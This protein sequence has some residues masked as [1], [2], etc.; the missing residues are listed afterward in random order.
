MGKGIGFAIGL[1]VIGYMSLTYFTP[2]PLTERD[3]VASGLEQIK[4]STDL[5]PR[6]ESMMR[7]QL[8]IMDQIA[9]TGSPPGSLNELVPNYFDAVPVDPETKE[10]FE[11]ER[12]P[13]GKFRIGPEVEAVAKSSVTAEGE[14]EID[15]VLAALQEGGE[16]VNPNTMKAVNYI[17]TVGEKRDPFLPFNLSKKVDTDIKKYPLTAYSIGQLRVTAILAGADGSYTAIVEDNQGKGF[18]VKPGSRIGNAGGEVIEIEE[19]KLK[20]LESY[21]NFR[22]EE[23]TNAVEMKLDRS[24]R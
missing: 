22:G 21:V 24:G 20:I 3:V 8:A 18:T 2:E 1:L 7:V 6:E 15:P 19:T 11:Y 12:K 5:S 10:A 4:D 14:E 13:G 23:V 16:F 9:K 17:Y